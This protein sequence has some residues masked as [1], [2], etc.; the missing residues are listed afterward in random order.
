[1]S[2]LSDR[3]APID[4]I[5]DLVGH[6]GIATTRMVYRHQLKPVIIEGAELIDD[7]VSD[8]SWDLKGRNIG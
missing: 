1:M 4:R 2:I 7:T 8:W 3:G 5:A 6:Q